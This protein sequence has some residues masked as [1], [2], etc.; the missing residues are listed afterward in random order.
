MTLTHIDSKLKTPMTDHQRLGNICSYTTVSYYASS[1]N[2]SSTD[3]TPHL[4][5]YH[6]II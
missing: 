2:S 3:S 1:Y 4:T 5:E 6:N